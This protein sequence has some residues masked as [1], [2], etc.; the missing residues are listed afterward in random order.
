MNLEKD[1]LSWHQQAFGHT[2]L[3]LK[4]KDDLRSQKHAYVDTICEKL[5]NSSDIYPLLELLGRFPMN[6]KNSS[7]ILSF[8]QILDGLSRYQA[9]YF[10]PK[11]IILKDEKMSSK[12]SKLKNFRLNLTNSM[13][14]S[15]NPISNCAYQ[16]NKQRIKMAVEWFFNDHI[17]NG[18]KP[19][20]FG[21]CMP[22]NDT[23]CEQMENFLNELN[24]MSPNQQNCKFRMEF[25]DNNNCTLGESKENTFMANRK[26]TT[27]IDIFKQR[28]QFEK[29]NTHNFS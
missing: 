20:L 5:C 24:N 6:K 8:E 9:T 29:S 28:D 2:L 10:Q 19:N 23:N 14:N 12:K 17:L 18:T 22:N 1:L 4:G 26:P 3:K 27:P 16:C 25:Y 11:E 7:E 15:L 13:N 21:N